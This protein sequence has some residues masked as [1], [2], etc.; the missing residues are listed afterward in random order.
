MGD[1]DQ[2]YDPWPAH[3]LHPPKVTGQRSYIIPAGGMDDPTTTG[4]TEGFGLMFY[5]A[6]WYDPTLGRFAQADTIIPQQT[7]GT[8]AWDRYA[9]T[10]NNPIKYADPSGHWLETAFDVIS[11]GMTIN[12]IRNEGFTVINT[13]SL[14]TDVA[15]IVIPVVPAGASH[16]LRAT[17]YASKAVDVVDNT[18]DAA[19]IIDKSIDIAKAADDVK[20]GANILDQPSGTGFSSVY[21]S[22][23]ETF[24]FMPSLDS[25]FPP[26]GWV[27]RYG[28]HQDVANVMIGNGS[29]FGDL[30]GFA[31]K[32]ELPNTLKI[33]SWNSGIL[34]PQHGARLVPTDTQATIVEKLISGGWN[35]IR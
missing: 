1:V 34:N 23:T 20:I 30:Y 9:Y 4:A 27:Q 22:A 18:A 2:R 14:V 17:K 12:D 8:Q 33:E 15:A 16:V 13:I 19:K 31:V 32:S 3:G 6:R 29:N 26:P 10:N 11:L 24:A 7:Q 21:D 28:G 35:V 25:F 5:N